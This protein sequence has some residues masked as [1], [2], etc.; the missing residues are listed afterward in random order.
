[1]FCSVADPD[2]ES[3]AFLISGSGIIF[4][5]WVETVFVLKILKFVDADLDLGSLWPWIRYKHSGSA[6]LVFR[7]RIGRN[8]DPGPESQSMRIRA[9]PDPYQPLPSQL[10]V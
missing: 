3:V 7:I 1:V 2:P 9:H 4:Q 6:T 8:T 10:R 5:R